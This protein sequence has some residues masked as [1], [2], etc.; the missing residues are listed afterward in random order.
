MNTMISQTVT[1][2]RR[3][4]VYTVVLTGE[5]RGDTALGEVS[6]VLLN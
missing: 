4:D 1:Q 3:K 6:P 5:I 2:H